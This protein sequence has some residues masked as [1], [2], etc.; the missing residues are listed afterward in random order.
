[1]GQE[2][3]APVPENEA[4]GRHKKNTFVG[5]GFDCKK[6]MTVLHFITGI[7]QDDIDYDGLSI[8]LFSLRVVSEQDCS[9][10]I[11]MVNTFPP[12]PN[13]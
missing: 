8:N 13:P 7:L 12:Y 2:E 3:T 4:F 1:M 6:Q 11:P 5:R 10:L 9:L